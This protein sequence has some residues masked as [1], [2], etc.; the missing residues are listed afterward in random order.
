MTKMQKL[1]KTVAENQDELIMIVR[2]IEESPL[3]GASKRYRAFELGRIRGTIDKVSINDPNGSIKIPSDMRYSGRL[4]IVDLPK[5]ERQSGSTLSI[6]R[7]E[8]EREGTLIF[9]SGW[10]SSKK[11]LERIGFYAGQGVEEYIRGIGGLEKAY[12]DF[13]SRVSNEETKFRKSLT[14]IIA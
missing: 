6:S 12:E 3:V 5:A 4:N 13:M 8:F 7:E 10:L 11:R 9:P 14:S 1:I 2:T